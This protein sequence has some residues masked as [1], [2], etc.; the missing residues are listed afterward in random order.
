MS[1]AAMSGIAERPLS[2]KQAEMSVLQ[3]VYARLA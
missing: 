1:L 2:I 3:N